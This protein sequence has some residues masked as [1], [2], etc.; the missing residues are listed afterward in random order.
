MLSVKEIGLASRLLSATPSPAKVPVLTWRREYAEGQW[1]HL[2][3]I[4]ELGHYSVIAGYFGRLKPGG[5][6]LDVACGEGILQRHL[7]PHRYS[8]YLGID[9]VPEAIAAAAGSRDATTDFA[10]ADAADYV[11]EQKFDVIIFNE[12]LYY[13]DD[14]IGMLQRYADFLEAGGIFVISNYSSLANLNMIRSIRRALDIGDEISIINRDGISWTVQLAEPK[15][16]A[17]A[18][19]RAA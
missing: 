4:G 12:C 8:R 15:R 9:Y 18:H 3:Q 13:F 10:I 19:R 6:V 2:D 17:G 16:A 1:S 7:K 11:A 14:P 5:T